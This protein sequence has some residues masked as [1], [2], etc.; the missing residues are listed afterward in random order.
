MHVAT[1]Q[2]KRAHVG[3]CQGSA[4]FNKPVPALGA[5]ITMAWGALMN[6][7]SLRHRSIGASEHVLE[8]EVLFKAYCIQS[9]STVHCAWIGSSLGR[10]WAGK[11]ARPAL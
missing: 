7:L 2:A 9:D 6:A 11:T 10:S 8:F 1:V 3:W 5:G 4:S